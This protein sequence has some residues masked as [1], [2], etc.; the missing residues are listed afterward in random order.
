MSTTEQPELR[1]VVKD[2]GRTT[3]MDYENAPLVEVPGLTFEVRHR[4]GTGY[5]HAIIIG[6]TVSWATYN[7]GERYLRTSSR[8]AWAHLKNI[9]SIRPIS[10]TPEADA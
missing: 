8:G 4:D 6:T 1:L 3:L 5:L 9:Y 10:G 7:M 2:D